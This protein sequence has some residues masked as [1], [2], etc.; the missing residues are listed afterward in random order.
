[1]S[2]KMFFLF[3]I[4]S[5]RHL[6]S[7]RGARDTLLRG[8]KTPHF[9]DDDA[10]LQ[11]NKVPHFGGDDALFWSGGDPLFPLPLDGGGLGRGCLK[12]EQ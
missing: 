7:N 2:R 8:N 5:R 1:M 4:L 3:R 6:A 9:W 11:G 12:I 10:F